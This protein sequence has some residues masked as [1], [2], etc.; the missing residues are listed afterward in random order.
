MLI[1]EYCSWIAVGFVFNGMLFIANA[2]FNNIK[3]A[4]LA[5][6]SSFSRAILGTI[7][8]VY[9]FA[10][11]WGPVGVLAGEIAG[12][13][14]FGTIALVVAF[15]QIGKLEEKNSLKKIQ[16]N[17][18]AICQW[19]YSS[20]KSALGQEIIESHFVDKK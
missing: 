5:T 19:P 2:T 14:V 20:E 6:V 12:A 1:V 18:P 9:L 17:E 16:D 11:W 3:A 13:A 15:Y 10:L 4:H 7:P 8:F